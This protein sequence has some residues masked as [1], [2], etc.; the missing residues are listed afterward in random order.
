MLENNRALHTEKEIHNV[1]SASAKMYL[2][3][4]NDREFDN[5]G[6]LIRNGNRIGI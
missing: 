5:Y 4:A 3:I 1:Q 6:R 2:S